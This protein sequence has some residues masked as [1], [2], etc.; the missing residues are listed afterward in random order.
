MRGDLVAIPIMVAAVVARLT[1]LPES[2]FPGFLVDV[3]FFCA[4]GGLIGQLS[5]PS[6]PSTTR[7]AGLTLGALT[8]TAILVSANV[9]DD[10]VAD[11]AYFVF[12]AG[13]VGLIGLTLGVWGADRKR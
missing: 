6:R 12:I 9:D 1:V 11:A 10:S 5:R 13:L 4:F 3:V 7:R 2:D 8:F